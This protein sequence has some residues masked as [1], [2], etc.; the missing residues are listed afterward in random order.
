MTLT[1]K[2]GKAA[3]KP[4]L[5]NLH[6]R[7]VNAKYISKLSRNLQVTLKSKKGKAHLENLHLR[8]G[9]CFVCCQLQYQERK[10][11]DKG[12]QELL[13]LVS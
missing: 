12:K 7:N 8:N 4:H 2:K 6:L 1:S 3:N 11:E 9:Q 13:I 10:I 5:E